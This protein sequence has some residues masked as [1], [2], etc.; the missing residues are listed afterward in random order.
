MASLPSGQEDGKAPAVPI[1]LHP[2]R[3]FPEF[4]ELGSRRL[5]PQ[6]RLLGLSLVVGVI[7]GLGAIVF[8]AACQLV[9]ALFPRS[10]RRLPSG[11]A[12]AANSGRCCTKRIP[13]LRPWLLLV[14][15]TVG[16]LLSGLIVFTP[17]AR[18]RGARHRRGHRR[19]SLPPGADSPAGA[20]GQDRRQRAD[21]RHGRIG[22]TRRADCADRGRLRLVSWRRA[23]AASCRA[24]HPDGGRHGRGHRGHLS[25]AAGRGAVRRRGA[26][27]L[28][29][30][31]V[32]SDHSRGPGQRDRLLHVR[33]G[34][35]LDAAVH[36]HARSDRRAH[37]RQPAA[38]GALHAAGDGRWSCWR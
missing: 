1:P 19:L 11:S 38:V 18:G 3:W 32:G 25:R 10:D 22:R 23:A 20:A 33:L 4:W 34:V 37:V 29:R 14:V 12:Q 16:G 17:G 27:S 26:L 31:R 13:P 7:S 5:R 21:P 35:R 28:A 2:L 9:I 30:L 15:P 36:S 24:A 6:M 8:F